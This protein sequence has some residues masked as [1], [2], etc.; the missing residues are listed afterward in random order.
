MAKRDTPIQQLTTGIAKSIEAGLR[1]SASV[2]IGFVLLMTEVGP[3]RTIGIAS[4]V[5]GEA[6]VIVL[7]SALRGIYSEN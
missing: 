1:G 5:K 2:E 7:K 6:V 3:G 4:N